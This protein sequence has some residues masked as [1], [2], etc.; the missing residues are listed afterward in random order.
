LLSLSPSRAA[1]IYPEAASTLV[2]HVL[3]Y[4]RDGVP[5]AYGSRRAGE[6]WL[7][8]PDLVT[9]HLPAGSAVLT[10]RTASAD[11][12][13]DSDAVLDAYY[14]TALP[15]VAQA[16]LGLEVL[17]GSAVVV[18]S[19]GCVAA[20]CGMSESGKS[21]VA[22]G[23]AVRGYRRWS[24]DAL[25]FRVDGAQPVTAVGLPFAVKLRERSAAH[26]GTT[27]HG[28]EVVEDSAW[29]STRL[30][31]VFILEPTNPECSGEAVAIDRLVPGDAL[32]ALLPNAYRFQPQTDER[33]RETMRSYL[34]LVASVPIFTARFR[35][36]LHRLPELLD[37]L[38][39]WMS[40]VVTGRLT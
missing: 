23:L 8:V 6:L 5:W 34:E 3:A 17:H 16:T 13:V 21:T 19:Q 33:R 28:V 18:P 9:F 10:A 11:D 12:S 35:R 40:V 20:F 38:E 4:D 39:Q 15:L 25:A 24:D 26:F 22:Y 14:G 29:K 1:N 36:G 2:R 37:E 32:H 31:A 7:E 27:S 30:G